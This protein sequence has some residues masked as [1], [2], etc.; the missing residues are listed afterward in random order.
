MNGQIKRVKSLKK[1]ASRIETQFS[2]PPKTTALQK[3]FILLGA[4]FFVALASLTA[5]LPM[6]LPSHQNVAAYTIN[7]GD[8]AWMIVATTFAFFAGPAAAYLFGKAFILV[9]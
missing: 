1:V 3:L 2:T 5:S 9:I 8:T 4:G 6:P 7:G